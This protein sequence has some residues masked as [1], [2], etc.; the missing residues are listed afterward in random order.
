VYLLDTNIVSLLESRRQAYS[1]D[2]IAW[3]RRNGSRLH[4]S[5]I[6][7]TE[8]EAGI[9]KLR[10]E[11]KDK[12]AA[13]LDAFRDG[14]VK[15]FSDRILPLDA[16]VA[17]CIPRLAERAR[18]TTIELVDL[19]VAATAEIHGCRVLTRNL[20]HFEPTGVRAIDPTVALPANP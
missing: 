14:L 4:L 2:L 8:I 3:L 12:R 20:R 11:S 6:T 10:R 16:A 5:A 19:I 13:E 18:P 15:D 17:L 7:L 1:P 9:L